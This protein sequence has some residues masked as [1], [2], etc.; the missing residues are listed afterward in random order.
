VSDVSPARRSRIIREVYA[1]REWAGSI[2]G[3]RLEIKVAVKRVLWRV[4]VSRHWLEGESP[5]VWH[6]IEAVESAISKG[7]TDAKPAAPLFEQE[8]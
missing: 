5:D 7:W 8:R 4:C 2:H 6:A 3:R 1:A